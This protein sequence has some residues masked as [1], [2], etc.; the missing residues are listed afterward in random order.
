MIL[1]CNTCG[2][3]LVEVEKEIVLQDDKDLYQNTV[4][5]SICD[6]QDIKIDVTN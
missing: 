2:R 4:S 1:T 3:E 6:P 5:C